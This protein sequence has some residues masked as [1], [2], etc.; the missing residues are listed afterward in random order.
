M[1]FYTPRTG[2][3]WLRD[4]D[5]GVVKRLGGI[6]DTVA[7]NY[8]INV[9]SG[10]CLSPGVSTKIPVIFGDP[11]PLFEKKIY[12]SFSVK[13]DSFLP[14]LERWH[15]TGQMQEKWG[16][17]G[18]EVIVNSET[19]YN[20]VELSP[21]AWPYT[22]SYTISIY[23]RYEYEALALIEHILRKFPPRSHLIIKDSLG[24]DRSYDVFSDSDVSNISEL[25]DVSER[26]KGY[27][28][29]ISVEAELDFDD[30]VIVDTVQS[31]EVSVQKS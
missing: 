17:T 21:Q 5:L 27:S 22:I 16:V 30:P 25:I 19:F 31:V 15:S 29:S 2:K 14:A 26:M 24:D 9:P 10:T 20:Q 23:S 28:L 4:F 3:V 1:V 8:F 11:E 6:L 7:N 12:P 18:T 13:R